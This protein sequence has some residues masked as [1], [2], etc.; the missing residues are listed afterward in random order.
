[1]V[2]ARRFIEI[3]RM[4]ALISKTIFATLNPSPLFKAAATLQQKLAKNGDG[5]QRNKSVLT[6][7]DENVAAASTDA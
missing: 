4:K 1:M 2:V 3:R 7:R 5:L 6:R